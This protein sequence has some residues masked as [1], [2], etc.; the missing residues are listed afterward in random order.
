MNCRMGRGEDNDLIDHKPIKY[1]ESSL[2][3]KWKS[4]SHSVVSYS[5]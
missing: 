1:P 5:L 2:F 4:V 3:G